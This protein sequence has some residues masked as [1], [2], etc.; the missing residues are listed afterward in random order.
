MNESVFQINVV[1]MLRSAGFL[2]FAVPN[3]GSRH[4]REA[5]NLRLQGVMAGVSDLVVVLPH[6]KV[7]FVELKNPNGTGRQSPAQSDFEAKVELLGHTYQLW[8]NW[9]E[10]EVFIKEQRPALQAWINELKIGGTD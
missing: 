10:V 6:G 4:Y 5:H 9:T 8:S 7:C 1:R 3:G 2:V